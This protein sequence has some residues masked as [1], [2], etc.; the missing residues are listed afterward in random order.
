MAELRGFIDITGKLVIEPKFENTFYEPFLGDGVA[1]IR[2]VKS[3][4]FVV[5]DK[6]E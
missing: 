4:E 3:D 2:M 1:V 6:T 5:I